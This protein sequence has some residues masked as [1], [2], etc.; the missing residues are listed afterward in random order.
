MM[1]KTMVWLAA[2]ALMLTGCSSQ[3]EQPE[4]PVTL[5][6]LGEDE[7][8][9]N[10]KYGYVF[11]GTHP[12]YKIEFISVDDARREGEEALSVYSRLIEQKQPDVVLLPGY[13]YTELPD[14]GIF[15]PLSDFIHRDQYNFTEITPAVAG[16]LKDDAGEVIGLTPAFTGSGLFYNK[17]IFKKYGMPTPTDQMSWD[18]LFELAQ[19]FPST[20][21]GEK[22]YGYFS[23][24]QYHP[25]MVALAVGQSKG[26]TLYNGKSFMLENDSWKRVFQQV[27]DCYK[28]RVC[29]DSSSMEI[30]AGSSREATQKANHP[31][32]QGNIAM[33]NDSTELYSLLS[34]EDYR[35]A[36]LE[37]GL[38]S[39]PDSELVP[40]T[41]SNIRI[42]DFVSIPSNAS[43]KEGAWEFI[44]YVTSDH[45]GRMIAQAY[46]GQL[47]T[48]LSQ[49]EKEG[50]ASAFYAFDRMDNQLFDSLRTIDSNLYEIGQAY[51]NELIVNQITVDDAIKQMQAELYAK[52]KMANGRTK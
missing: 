32:L 33:A 16:L 39:L 24:E 48:R 18:E 31:F 43:Q 45:Y 23:Y 38:I 42:T 5:K 11:G 17:K 40:G 14:K 44:N 9:F 52:P 7:I 47:P 3:A 20:A 46:S 35:S 27:T 10:E 50:E 4:L 51:F 6:I 13:L 28:A 37:W 25:F 12:N 30:A 1:K 19:R 21:D 22:Q 2:S 29:A 49:E 8:D 26:L 36:D 15:T 41:G 34:S